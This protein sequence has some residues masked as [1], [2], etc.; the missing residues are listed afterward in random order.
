MNTRGALHRLPPGDEDDLPVFEPRYSRSSMMTFALCETP[1]QALAQMN[2]AAQRGRRTHAEAPR[3][4]RRLVMTVPPG[5]PLAER[6]IFKRRAE[7][8]RDLV[9]KVLNWRL[10]DP[11]R[12]RPMPSSNGT[13]PAAPSSSTSTPRWRE[14]GW[15]RAPLRAIAAARRRRAGPRVASIDI[16]GG[17][18]DL[19]I[20]TYTVEGRGTR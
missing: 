1:L 4:L 8:A 20:N 9:W 12:R 13:R 2:S 17:T 18:T 15:R 14:L 6:Q 3:R 10:D 16:R 11:R 19:I 7:T 5:M